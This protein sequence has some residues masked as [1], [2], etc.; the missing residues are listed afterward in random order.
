METIYV[1]VGNTSIGAACFPSATGDWWRH[2]SFTATWRTPADLEWDRLPSPPTR[3][4]VATVNSEVA[5]HLQ[6][7]VHAQR[8]SDVW[9]SITSDVFPIETRVDDKSAVGADRLAAAVAANVLRDPQRPAV[10]VD[11]GSAINV[12]L[13]DTAGV[14]CGGAILPGMAMS[15]QALAS[16]TDLL[17]A[18]SPA[19]APPVAVGRNTTEAIRSGLYWGSWGAI[20]ELARKFSSQNDAP[21]DVFLTGG[22]IL[23]SG[24]RDDLKCEPHLVLAG[25]AIAWRR[26]VAKGEQ[27]RSE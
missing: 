16:N 6:R 10:V 25:I 27:E 8:P 11:A 15:A 22:G 1:D 4:V 9:E 13:I 23:W 18:V 7:S 24:L 19:D 14:H 26:L 5:D 2:A 21:P 3:W 12:E 17:P 20:Q